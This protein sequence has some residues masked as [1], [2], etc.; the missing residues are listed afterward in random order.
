MPS[1]AR[2]LCEVSERDGERREN[3]STKPTS[4]E[5]AKRE[6]KQNSFTASARVAIYMNDVVRCRQPF[7]SST[8][9]YFIRVGRESVC[10]G[11]GGGDG[12]GSALFH[13]TVHTIN[14]RKWFVYFIVLA[15]A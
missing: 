15:Y 6:W 7:T 10:G 12:N 9:L 13:A 11:G 2:P 1:L 14:E 3:R 8:K 4:N 5:E